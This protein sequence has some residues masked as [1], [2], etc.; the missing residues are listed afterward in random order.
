[1]MKDS[2]FR[3]CGP[4]EALGL[5]GALF[6]RTTCAGRLRSAALASPVSIIVDERSRTRGYLHSQRRAEPAPTFSA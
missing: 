3:L 6:G 5:R 4:R 2:A 1:M